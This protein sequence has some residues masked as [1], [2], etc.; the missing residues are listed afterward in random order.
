MRPANGARRSP[1]RST[2]AR[3]VVDVAA[4]AS[5]RADRALAVVDGRR[6]A[7][8]SS[9][10][11]SVL[12]VLLGAAGSR[13][14]DGRESPPRRHRPRAGRR[15]PARLRLAR[16]SPRCRSPSRYSAARHARTASG[17][18]GARQRLAACRSQRWISRGDG[19]A[20]RR[21]EL[22]PLHLPRPDPLPRGGARRAAAGGDRLLATGLPV[23]PGLGG[24]ADPA[25]AALDRACS[26]RRRCSAA[27][28]RP[29]ARRS[30]SAARFL[31]LA[32]FG[33]WQSAMVTLVLD[34]HRGAVRRRRR[35]RC[36]ASPASARPR[37]RARCCRR[38]S[39]A[40]RPCRSSPT[41]CRSSS[42]SASG[43]WRRWSPP[44]STPCRRWCGSPCWRSRRARRRSSSSAAW[45]AARAR[46]LIWRVMMPAARA[47]LMVGVNQVIMLSL[48][49]VIIASMIGAGGLGYDVLTALRR[50][51]IGARRRGGLAIVVLAIALDRLSQAYA[52][53]RRA[54]PRQPR[55][56]RSPALRRR[57][58]RRSRLWA[59]GVRRPGARDLSGGA[60]GLD[61]ELLGRA[62]RVAERQL[63]RHLRGDQDGGPPQRARAGEALPAGACPGSVG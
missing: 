52:A 42:S 39:T 17:P 21:R 29:A 31:Y 16:R 56:D 33:Q 51:D 26:R 5:R 3:K 27:C 37:L 49:M 14:D 7:S 19:L 20:G 12:D 32:V 36:S 15:W 1:A 8:A 6:D 30:S 60:A 2:P 25:A 46:Q 62:G 63:L 10:G 58:R 47:P 4:R 18:G 9:T 41:S 11:R 40:C 13:R 28:R 55:P 23:G 38:S 43:R 54:R 50:L 45:P 53:A 44:S 61:R 59:A 24:G 35:P 48:N 34:R 22:R 57:W